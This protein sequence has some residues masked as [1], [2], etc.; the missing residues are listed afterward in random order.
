MS[1]PELEGPRF[2]QL[3]LSTLRKTSAE[4]LGFEPQGRKI[5]EA[6]AEVMAEL[7]RRRHELPYVCG[8]CN[9]SLDG[10]MSK[11]WACGSVIQDE[12]EDAPR[13]TTEEVESRAGKLG[14]DP[15]EKGEEELRAEVEAAEKRKR[16]RR[17]DLGGMEAERLNEQ[18]TEAMG[19]GWRKDRTKLYISYFDPSGQKRIGVY[20]RGLQVQF[21]VNDGVLDHF[22]NLEFLDKDARRRRHT[23]RTNYIYVGDVSREALEVALFVLRKYS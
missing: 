17:G 1:V 5:R 16:N 23:G 14:I 13:M 4:V 6:H 7:D 12:A 22:E 15:G 9:S 2:K 3:N 20:N 11:C 10:E 21:S 8:R 18:L 19:D